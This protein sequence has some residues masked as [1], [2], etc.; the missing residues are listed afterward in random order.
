MAALSC[1]QLSQPRPAALPPWPP[2]VQCGRSVPHK[3]WTGEGGDGCFVAAATA[4]ASAI[5][6]E[7]CRSPSRRMSAQRGPLKLY[8]ERRAE[9]RTPEPK[10]TPRARRYTSVDWVAN[11]RGLWSSNLLRR[12][13]SPVLCTT[14]VAVLVCLAHGYLLPKG[15]FWHASTT[16][17][18]LLVSALGLLL[19]F[20]TNTAYSRFWEGRQIWQRI[21]DLGR[22]V[23]RYAIIFRQ[24]MGPQTSAHVCR[25]VQAFPYCMIEHLRGKKDRAM[26][27]KLERLIGPKGELASN[28]QHDYTLPMSSN[29]PLFIVNQ[30]AHAVRSVPNGEGAQAM[31]TNRERSQLL[32]NLEKLSSTIGACERLVQ[33]PVPLSYVRHTSRFLSLFM[34]TLPFALVDVL[35]PYTVPVT[36][37]ASWALFGIFEIGLVI[38]DPFQGVLKVEVIAD[39]LQVDI[40]ESIRSLG[41]QDLLEAGALGVETPKKDKKSRSDSSYESSRVLPSTG[42]ELSVARAADQA[43]SE[44]TKKERAQGRRPRLTMRDV[45]PGD[46]SRARE[47]VLL[48]IFQ[49]Y[50]M[51]GDK[52]IDKAEMEKVL[53]DTDLEIDIERIEAIFDEADMDHDGILT[54]AEWVEWAEECF[55]KAEIANLVL[56]MPSSPLLPADT[57]D[58]TWDEKGEEDDEAEHAEPERPE[59]EELEP[60]AA[61]QWEPKLPERV[62]D[63]ELA[64]FLLRTA[65]SAEKLEVDALKKAEPELCKRATRFQASR[66]VA[67]G[68]FTADVISPEG[69]CGLGYTTLY[70]IPSAD[71]IGLQSRASWMFQVSYN[72]VPEKRP[73]LPPPPTPAPTPVERR[74]KDEDVDKEIRFVWCRQNPAAALLDSQLRLLYYGATAAAVEGGVPTVATPSENDGDDPLSRSHDKDPRAFQDVKAPVFEECHGSES[75]CASAE[76]L[77][78]HPVLPVCPKREFMKTLADKRR[79]EK[80]EEEEERSRQQFARAQDRLS[81]LLPLSIRIRRWAKAGVLCFFATASRST[82]LL[83]QGYGS[84]IPSRSSKAPGVGSSAVL[85]ASREVENGAAQQEDVD[86]RPARLRLQD[87]QVLTLRASA[88]RRAEWARMRL[89]QTAGKAEASQEAPLPKPASWNDNQRKEEVTRERN[90]L[91]Q[92]LE[93]KRARDLEEATQRATLTERRQSLR[94]QKLERAATK[95][96]Q[97]RVQRMLELRGEERLPT[98]Q[99]ARSMT[100]LQLRDLL[101][102]AGFPA[103]GLPSAADVRELSAEELKARLQK[104]KVQFLDLIGPVLPKA[105]EPSED[106]GKSER[107]G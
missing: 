55:E 80:R 34:L 41:A 8:A 30:L 62:P 81:E 68:H 29:R 67:D 56:R 48:Q 64:E 60:P 26:R 4:T 96:E 5:A 83:V 52:A 95:K 82:G 27:S 20:R 12:I 39:T 103:K 59:E 21:L 73:V 25:L 32:Q 44:E 93:A 70:T 38:E 7:R 1:A 23:S 61:V 101:W 65:D 89:G 51:N 35:G 99:Q 72:E 50:D 78:A 10:G 19:V 90:R 94:R 37:F 46:W 40:E 86:T 47:Q 91:F 9:R 57:Q 15:K 97:Q 2:C 77:P 43:E 104:V 31:Y 69:V 63:K 58:D 49:S 13:L 66:Q 45:D 84:A 36:C 85:Q 14:G 16:G 102:K 11:L 71:V 107:G 53:A 18:A 28:V 100:V 74:A 6:V 98:L 79:A 3:V 92:R 75:S 105:E 33:T 24:E 87:E 106:D 22:D 54:Q 76:S 42:E 17:H 88:R